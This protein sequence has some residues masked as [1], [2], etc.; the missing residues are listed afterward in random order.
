LIFNPFFSKRADHKNGTGLGL[1]ICKTLV[2]NHGGR[3]EVTSELGHGCNFTV[4][5]PKS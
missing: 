3:I 1:S 4:I 5:L 2:E